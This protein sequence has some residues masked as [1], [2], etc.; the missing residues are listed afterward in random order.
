MEPSMDFPSTTKIST[1][2]VFKMSKTA[3]KATMVFGRIFTYPLYGKNKK[4]QGE[5]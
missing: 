1:T 4:N 3:D 5:N 2:K